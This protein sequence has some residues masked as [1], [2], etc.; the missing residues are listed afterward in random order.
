MNECIIKVMIDDR[1][2]KRTTATQLP[3]TAAIRDVI[4]KEAAR[5]VTPSKEDLHFASFETIEAFAEAAHLPL[6]WL[7]V[8][9]FSDP[10]DRGG[11]VNEEGE[12]WLTRVLERGLADVPTSVLDA[13]Y[14]YLR[15]FDE[16][17]P[18]DFLVVLG[19]KTL[20]R[21]QKAA[22]LYATGIA[23]MVIVSGKGANYAE[24]GAQPEW[25][26]Y[27]DEMIR[28]GVPA[29]A[30]LLEKE[31][32]SVPDNSF[33]VL[34]LLDSTGVSGAKLGIITSDFA[35]RR[36]VAHFM[37]MSP[38]GTEVFGFPCGTL[39]QTSKEEWFKNEVGIRTV[40]NEYLKIKVG[41]ETNKI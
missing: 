30:I 39:P 35:M 3:N 16:P 12:R 32:I 40:L 10:I 28:L 7:D 33:R 11:W 17:R 26:I 14:D 9:P 41:I 29:D 1:I 34:N 13:V 31:A 4:S 22:E 6:T 8:P 20:L 5:S 21:P 36:S 24:V 25:Q 18:C 2:D 38:E 37:K 15:C 19:G 23:Q 27:R